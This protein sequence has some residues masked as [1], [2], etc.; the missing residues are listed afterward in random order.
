LNGVRAARVE[1][2]G[3][4]LDA[5][6]MDE[7]V[8]RIDEAI[9]ERRFL[10]H[11]DLNGAIVVAMQGDD[12]LRESIV[13]ADLVVADGQS[14]VWAARL[15][16]R[17][18]PARVAGIDLMHRTIELAER[19]GYSIYIL[20]AR[21]EVLERAVQRLTA[22]HPDLKVAGYRNGYFDDSEDPAVAAAIRESGADI[23]FVA[24]S[25]PR[26]EYFL[27]RYG[28]GLGVP[29]VMG[30]GGS[31]DVVAGVARRAPVWMQRVGLEWAFRLVQEPRRLFRRYLVTNAR[32]IAFVARE[33]LRRR[34]S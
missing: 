13:G 18:L 6:D 25:S 24:I 21:Q 26:K 5:V 23:L 3:C 22:D 15:L 1:V 11:A 33:A 7:A 12:E 31:I 8:A 17:P 14:V 28:R 34:S 2:L 4:A 30:V 32:F 19:R 20:G 10:R 27:G 9:G 29:Y 16:G